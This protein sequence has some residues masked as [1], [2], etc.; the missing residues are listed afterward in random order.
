MFAE[1]PGERG[2]RRLGPRRADRHRDRDPLGPLGELRRDEASASASAAAAC[3][4]SP[5]ARASSLAALRD[6][7][8][9]RLPRP[10]DHRHAALPPAPGASS[11]G[12][13]SATTPGAC[14]STSASAAPTG[15]SP[16]ATRLRNVLPVLLAISANSPFLDGRDTGLASVRTQ[17]FTRTFPRCGIHDPFGDW[18]DL[19]GLRRPARADQLDRRVDAALVERPAP[20]RLRHRRG[21]DLRRAERR[22]RSRSALAGLMVAAVAQAAPTTTTACLAAA[23]PRPRARGEPLAGDPPRPRRPDDR[24]RARD[25]RSR[26]RRRSRS[27]S[28]GPRRPAMALGIDLGDFDPTGP[29]GAQRA[30]AELL[31]AGASIAEAYRGVGRPDGRHLPRVAG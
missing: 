15:R 19:R 23:A 10:G 31:E 28:S 30:R 2:P 27:C 5:P 12:S 3:S 22:R 16:S 1:S 9:G 7:S 13:R 18:D 21:A 6:P 26:R 8:L 29:N 4:T 20:P 25:A 24:L 11:A 14:T 17:I